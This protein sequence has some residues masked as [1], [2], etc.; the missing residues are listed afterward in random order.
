[1]LVNRT[2]AHLSGPAV[3]DEL[4]VPQEAFRLDCAPDA[5]FLDARLA[6]GSDRKLHLSTPDSAY[7]SALLSLANSPGQLRRGD[8]SLH[9]E[10]SWIVP[11]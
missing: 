11:S 8:A 2:T 10:T 3:Q 4:C 6:A 9:P 5:T 7:I 1:V